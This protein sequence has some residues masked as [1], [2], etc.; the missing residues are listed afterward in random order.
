[1]KCSV[2]KKR[3]TLATLPNR[4]VICTAC[5]RLLVADGYAVVGV[6]KCGICS[7]PY[8]KQ[9]LVEG[10]VSVKVC[11]NCLDKWGGKEEP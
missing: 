3:G 2:C 9:E 4:T 10:L 5:V 1:M 11:K 6:M 7:A 8:T